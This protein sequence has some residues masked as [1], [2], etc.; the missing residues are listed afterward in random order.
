MSFRII[1]HSHVG[2][3]ACLFV[4]RNLLVL[5]SSHFAQHC[6]PS[7]RSKAPQFQLPSCS[8]NAN[9]YWLSRYLLELTEKTGQNFIFILNMQCYDF[10]FRYFNHVEFQT[11]QN[12]F[13]DPVYRNGLFPG[14]IN[15]L[16]YIG[17]LVFTQSL[18]ITSC[19]LINI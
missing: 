17:L 12:C 11:G 3:N 10:R 13:L 16:F 8:H 2:H 1:Q 6:K 4:V 14:S 19:R 15:M 9:N 18:S 7:P 5:K